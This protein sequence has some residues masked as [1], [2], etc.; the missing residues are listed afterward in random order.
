[1][2]KEDGISLIEVLITV[3]MMII[4]MGVAFWGYRERSNEFALR[5]SATEVATYIETVREMALSGQDITGGTER[6]LGGYGVRFDSTI[7]SSFII[8]ADDGDFQY[9]PGDT[10][11]D[12]VSLR[13]GVRIRAVTPLN[14]VDIVFTPPSPDVYINGSEVDEATITLALEVDFTKIKIININPIGL[15]TVE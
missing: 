1:M 11:E 2:K 4:L 13:D 10:I 3:T 9:G 15:I 5:Q 6:P 7:S 14:P 12:T 8:F